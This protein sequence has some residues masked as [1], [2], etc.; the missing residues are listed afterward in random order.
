MLDARPVPV[1]IGEA[2]GQLD[3][4][5]ERVGPRDAA[6]DGLRAV[7]QR[8]AVPVPVVVVRDAAEVVAHGH[9]VDVFDA[10][11]KRQALELGHA[12]RAVVVLDHL[13]DEHVVVQPAVAPLPREERADLVMARRPARLQVDAV[14]HQH[15]HTRLAARLDHVARR[16]RIEIAIGDVALEIQLRQ[17][18]AIRV[19]MRA[20]RQLAVELRLARDAPH[21]VGRRAGQEHAAPVV[22]MRP[23]GPNLL[24][25]CL[26]DALL[27]ILT[28]AARAR[29]SSRAC[30]AD[31]PRA[32]SSRRR[33]A[34]ASRRARAQARSD[35]TASR[36]ASG[37]PSPSARSGARSRRAP[38]RPR[39]ETRDCR[40]GC[41]RSGSHR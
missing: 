17:V 18:L 14:V 35:R 3:H 8:D 23:S 21:L 22:V 36:R 7:I 20:A 11:V 5:R 30:R 6:L 39:K 37:S 2:L 9:V 34:R 19:Q 15:Q 16:Q 12:R 10:A 32:R 28:R 31:S 25:E 41:A 13:L 1:V 24:S 40:C 33:P 26:H 4:H 29:P 38:P 27:S